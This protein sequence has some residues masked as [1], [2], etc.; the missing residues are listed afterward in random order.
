MAESLTKNSGK[1]ISIKKSKALTDRMLMANEKDIV[2]SA[3]DYSME[4]A[5]KVTNYI[6]LQ[7][8][9][10]KASDFCKKSKKSSINVV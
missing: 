4:K 2:Q 10:I 9:R 8:I 3:L 7:Y 5:A 6:I 1:E